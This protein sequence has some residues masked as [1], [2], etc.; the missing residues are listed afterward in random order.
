MRYALVTA[1]VALT[2]SGEAGAGYIADVADDFSATNN[3]TGDWE[4]GMSTS[5]GSFSKYTSTGNFL[6]NANLPAWLGLVFGSGEPWVLKNIS[7]STQTAS[8][9]RLEAGKLAFHPGPTGQYSI[10]R[11]TAPAANTY[12]FDV[13]FETRDIFHRNNVNVYILQD[14]VTQFS[15]NLSGTLGT[16]KSYSF[17]RTL[18]A[19]AK[20]DF[21]VGANGSFFNDS[22]GLSAEITAPNPVPEPASMTLLGIGLA[23]LFGYGWRRRKTANPQAA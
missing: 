19:D 10:V 8:G 9:L 17:S 2:L 7:G 21:V 6:A 1:I 3:P 18:A 11:W 13:T 22:T 14:G 16:K 23:G 5:L 12:A 20:I 15:H 4:Y